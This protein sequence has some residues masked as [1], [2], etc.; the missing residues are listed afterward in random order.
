MSCIPHLLPISVGPG[1]G[2]EVLNIISGDEALNAESY[3]L[4]VT[5][6]RQLA[7]G[8]HIG[9]GEQDCS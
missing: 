4:L 9:D 6:S 7:N 2:I 1:R 8:W 5:Q 3:G